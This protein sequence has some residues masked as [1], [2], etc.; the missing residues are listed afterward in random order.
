MAHSQ[1][2]LG[3]APQ[4]PRRAVDPTH[5]VRDVTW[6][7]TAP[8]SGPATGPGHGIATQ[9]RPEHPAS[10]GRNQPSP[11]HSDTTPATQS[12]HSMR[13]WPADS[14]LCRGPAYAARPVDVPHGPRPLRPT[15]CLTCMDVVFGRRNVDRELIVSFMYGPAGGFGL[16]F[17]DR[18]LGDDAGTVWL[19][20]MPCADTCHAGA[21][22]T[23]DRLVMVCRAAMRCYRPHSRGASPGPSALG[24]VRD[25]ALS[26]IP[27]RPCIGCCRESH[28]VLTGTPCQ[29]RVNTMDLEGGRVQAACG[30]CSAITPADPLVSS[31]RYSVIKSIDVCDMGKVHLICEDV[32]V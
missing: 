8:R 11:P 23:A 21:R 6:T 5:Y 13:S 18:W 12:D 22:P 20:W 26:N 30:T 28:F 4:A 7:K 16:I 15:S 10:D 32:S 24:S 29:R 14:R 25:M 2:L 19:A 3:P 17:R 31:L 27:D 9:P 1:N